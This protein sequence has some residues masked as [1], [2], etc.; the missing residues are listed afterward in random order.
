[1]DFVY[2]FQ[3]VQ[4]L[5]DTNHADHTAALN[6]LRHDLHAYVCKNDKTA[7][8]AACDE[9]TFLRAKLQQHLGEQ[10]MAMNYDVIQQ[11]VNA[12][13]TPGCLTCK[14][15]GSKEPW[16]LDDDWVE[17]RKTGAKVNAI[18]NKR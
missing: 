2:R 9:I 11:H 13:T 4:H 14:H 16:D 8:A 1:M 5:R 18:R 15:K 3:H 6:T 10:G 17:V 12:C 7:L